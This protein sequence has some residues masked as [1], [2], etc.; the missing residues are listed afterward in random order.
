VELECSTKFSMEHAAT[1]AAAHCH[2]AACCWLLWCVSWFVC[3]CVCAC[4]MC[5]SCIARAKAACGKRAVRVSKKKIK[6]TGGSSTLKL[7]LKLVF[8]AHVNL[9]LLNKKEE[10]TKS[11]DFCISC[12]S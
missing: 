10:V 4:A 7:Y 8:N 3:L 11:L 1:A 6:H 9:K 2:C 12:T 5:V